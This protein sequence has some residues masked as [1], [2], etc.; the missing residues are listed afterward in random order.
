MR[1]GKPK[2]GGNK[3]NK[4]STKIYFLIFAAGFVAVT[5]F[6]IGGILKSCTNDVKG[7]DLKRT[8]NAVG[9]MLIYYNYY[10][11]QTRQLILDE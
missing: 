9:L 1:R 10:Y 5:F 8:L 6:L 7:I 2:R 3:G 11:L 4:G